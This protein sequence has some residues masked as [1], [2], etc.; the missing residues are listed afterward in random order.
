MLL[1]GQPASSVIIAGQSAKLPPIAV[2]PWM[3][4]EYH[5]RSTL[6]ITDDI[7]D[8]PTLIT[9][10]CGSI[11]PLCW[12]G[13]S[14]LFHV[15]GEGPKDREQGWGSWKGGNQP[16]FHQLGGLEERCKLPSGVRGGAPAAKRF[17][18][19]LEPPYSLSWNLLGPSSGRGM[20]PL[21]LPPPSAYDHSRWITINN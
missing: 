21:P 9:L 15:R 3:S 19:I 14:L 11:T 18:C 17:S 8:R 5:T 6:P 13:P 10:I 1:H 7:V 2:S 20:T 12:E 4:C 16:P